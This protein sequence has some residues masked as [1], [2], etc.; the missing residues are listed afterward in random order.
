M[1]H[2]EHSVMVGVNTLVPALS[3]R[4]R[5]NGA[6]TLANPRQSRGLTGRETASRGAMFHV[7]H[8][9]T[10]ETNVPRGT[11]DSSG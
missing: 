4:E 3:R 8:C 5:E 9:I 7:K 2:V 1:F 10:G 11:L 6:N